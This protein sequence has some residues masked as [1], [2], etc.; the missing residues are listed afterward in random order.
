VNKFRLYVSKKCPKNLALSKLLENVFDDLTGGIFEFEVFS[1]LE[2]ADMAT[3]DGVLITPT[4][5]KS[6][7][8]PPQRF[9]GNLNNPKIVKKLIIEKRLD[10]NC[11]G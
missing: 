11:P 1:L 10:P 7:P 9:I 6:H 2:N 5:I 4:L 3:R 8:E